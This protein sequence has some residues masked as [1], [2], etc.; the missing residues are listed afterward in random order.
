MK[1]VFSRRDSLPDVW[2][3]VVIIV[4]VR[5]LSAHGINGYMYDTKLMVQLHILVKAP[6]RVSNHLY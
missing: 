6:I 1:L 5:L 4:E 3:L 2:H